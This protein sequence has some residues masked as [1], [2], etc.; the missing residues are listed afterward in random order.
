MHSQDSSSALGVLIPIFFVI[1]SLVLCI[2]VFIRTRKS[3][4]FWKDYLKRLEEQEARQKA[5][6]ELGKIK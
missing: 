1:V 2:V 6:E 3:D 4:K 5:L